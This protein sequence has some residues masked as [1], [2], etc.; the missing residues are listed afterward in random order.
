MGDLAI[1]SF[2]VKKS[3]AML[4]KISILGSTG[5]IGQSTL[6]IARHLKGEFEVV[7]LA[8]RSNIDLLYHQAIEFSPQ[9]IAVY[10]PTQAKLLQERLPDTPVLSGMEGLKE[11]ASGSS[12]DMVVSAMTGSVGIEPTLS[13]IEAG[14]NIALANKEVLVT[15]GEYVMARAR[16]KGVS[17]IPIDSEHSALFQCMEG[18]S[19]DHVRRMIL[20]ASGGPFFRFSEE[21][22]SNVTS[23][24]A[25]IHP[26][27]KMG[28]KVTIDSSTLMNKGLEVIEAHYLF[29]VPIDKIEVVIHPQS[30]IH[31]MVEYIDGS[32]L[33][34][35]SEPSMLIP[36]QYALTHPERK[37]GILP[38]FDFSRFSKM[39]F[40]PPDTNRFV[41]LDLAFQAL[42]QGGNAPCY[43]NAVNEVLVERFITGEISW[44]EISRKLEQLFTAFQPEKGL[45]LEGIFATDTLAREHAFKV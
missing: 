1:L 18:K 5:S 31:S 17:V 37:Q 22:L 12:A 35:M 27:W 9:I 33:A 38:R 8:A 16:A 24:Q 30:V 45:N 6:Q 26:N 28:P 44:I 20:T 19:P 13:A 36:I 39:E 7:A 42:R 10:D 15:A 4:R 14:K 32:M 2:S 34:Q 21:A 29:G 40:Y 25:L 23:E 43:L 41:C 3:R 11:V